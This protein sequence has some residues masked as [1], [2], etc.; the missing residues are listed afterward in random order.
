MSV[1]KKTSLVSRGLRV[2]LGVA[3]ALTSI[4]PFLTLL[5]TFTSKGEI[6]IFIGRM[7]FFIFIGLVVAGS[8]YLL[9]QNMISSVIKADKKART[10]LEGVNYR[11]F[12]LRANDEIEDLND[13]I[14]KLN[15]RIRDNIEKLT[16]YDKQTK[17][18]NLDLNKK[19]IVLSGL[20]QIGSFI[21]S[22]AKLENILSLIVEK[23]SNLQEKNFC[24]LFLK[25]EV[26]KN[27]ILE[28]SSDFNKIKP[29]S[30]SF[31]KGEYL[32]KDI[33]ENKDP[34]VLSSE[35]L[36]VFP[37]KELVEF[38]SLR[39]I[40][41]FPV[42]VYNNIEGFLIEGSSSEGFTYEEND[43]ELAR[44]FSKQISISLEKDRL[45][46]KAKDLE[47]KDELTDLYNEK[48][49]RSR[50]DEEIKRAFVSQRPCAFVIF[51]IDKFQVFRQRKGEAMAEKALSNI[52]LVFKETCRNIDKVAR[53][54]YSD[55]AILL[56]EM[57]KKEAITFSDN[58][59]KKIEFMY[60]E[61]QAHDFP[62]TVSAA[63]S[64]NPIDGVTADELIAHARNL[65][66]HKDADN[67]VLR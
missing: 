16:F 12:K 53:F 29:R 15:S 40:L 28:F 65:L 38:F 50:L 35:Q 10:L 22:Q 5:Y 54:G 31:S 67:K 55:F 36:D 20:L 62:L 17:E 43:I 25:D 42:T 49:I 33:L 52:S 48:F 66:T 34:V 58:A 45:F 63:V 39:S 24:F 8:G 1:F 18:I 3:F 30:F 27:F 47:I 6:S 37:I 57:D 7:G 51:T 2:K 61:S 56:P 64:E 11:S 32:F 13:A 46:K 14:D 19:I 23:V 4:I 41:V 60:K 9:L 21:S 59:R 44:L 26:S